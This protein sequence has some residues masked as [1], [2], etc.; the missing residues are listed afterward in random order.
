MT[1]G[2]RSA[3]G[4][5]VVTGAFSYSGYHVA[6]ELL[7]RGRRVK[8]LTNHPS[9][10]GPQ[11]EIEV[12]PLD[13]ADRAGLAAAMRGADTLYNTYWIRYEHAGATF[14]RAVD[15]TR[16][17]F[18]AAAQADVRRI[19]H[20]SVSNAAPS[21]SLLYFRGKAQVED[22]LRRLGRSYA[23]V[24]PTLIYGHG[25]VLINNIA[26]YLR[27]LPAFLVPGNGRYRVQPIFVEDFARSTVSVGQSSADTVVDLAGPDMVTFI[28]LVHE[29]RD[30]VRSR[31]VVSGA[32]P[33]LALAAAQLSGLLLRDVPLTRH[34][35]GGLM[36]EL[37]ISSQPPLGTTRLVDA[38]QREAA[39]LG[40]RYT[41]ELS[42][43]FRGVR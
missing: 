7:A 34:E 27:H 32:P 33:R 30:A 28:R 2:H 18:E 4:F 15:N 21:S 12:A 25:D 41:S 19:V 10:R 37:L 24:R 35:V 11:R 14:E 17:L 40:T 31:A 23:I 3:A 16:R 9:R 5:D 6:G 43:H 42:L 13:F 1:D 29:V 20:I 36:A 38:L 39:G 26:W 22:H 8:T